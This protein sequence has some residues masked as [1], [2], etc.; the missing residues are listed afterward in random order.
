VRSHP[1]VRA[2][3]NHLSRNIRNNHDRGNARK[4]LSVSLWR[5]YIL[6]AF[7]EAIIVSAVAM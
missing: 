3:R 4:A 5:G 6:T 7:P 2:V 1:T